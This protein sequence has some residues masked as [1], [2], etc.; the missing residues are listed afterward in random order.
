MRKLLVLS[1]LQMFSLNQA[2]ASL[3]GDPSNSSMESILNEDLIRALR[4]PF[5]APV[6]I[7]EVKVKTQSD[8]ELYQLRD[9]KL[10]GVVT[11][12]KKPRALITSPK[13]QSFFV[14]VGDLVGAREGRVTQITPDSV[15]VMEFY[16]DDKGK[17]L[18]DIYEMRMDG[19]LRSLDRKGRN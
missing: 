14:K 7:K 3:P 2:N 8:L 13:G 16:V 15:R 18:P 17:R 11:G 1:I 19:E 10:N 4:D 12:P 5:E 6:V 9:L